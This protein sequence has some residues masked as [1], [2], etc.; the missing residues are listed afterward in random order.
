MIDRILHPLVVY[1]KA[2]FFA[3]L[4]VLILY[5]SPSLFS[6]PRFYGEEGSNFFTF[7]YSHS[8]LHGLVVPAISYYSFFLN[9]SCVLAAKC[10]PLIYAPFVTTYLSLLLTLAP[11]VLVLWG[12]SLFFDTPLKQGIICLGTLFF[13]PGEIWIST[14]CS[15]F[16]LCLITFLIL[17]Q[18]V[19]ALNFFQRWFYRI[20]LGVAAMSG[21]LSCFLAP[22]FLMKYRHDRSR[23]NRIQM[24]IVTCLS[25]AQFSICALFVLFGPNT[26]RFQSAD[27]RFTV[28]NYFYSHFLYPL[29]G[30]YMGTR[31]LVFIKREEW[32]SSGFIG[33]SA[34]FIAYIVF[35]F[36]MFAST[37]KDRN[38]RVIIYSFLIVSILSTLL[39]IQMV[40]GPRYGFMPNI[41]LAIITLSQ[42][43]FKS[44]SAWIRVKSVICTVL[45][46][47]SLVVGAVEFRYRLIPYSDETWPKWREEITKWEEN[48]RYPIKIWP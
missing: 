7:A 23:E 1:R 8:W 11:I 48:H 6:E 15:Q 44:R 16:Y 40:S 42:I 19:N 21:V 20:A 37:L 28:L 47:T 34:I 35:A 26:T 2:L 5:R 45:I 4:V 12:R 17:I 38:K 14:T 46:F 24:V 22:F 36:I 43:D 29:F 41:V 3:F 33:L 13:S 25:I 10:V 39:S 18:D 32:W 27:L 30:Q 9:F 31:Y